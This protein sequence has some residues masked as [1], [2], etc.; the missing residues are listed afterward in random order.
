[1]SEIEQLK[2]SIHCPRCSNLHAH[3]NRCIAPALSVAP[4][5]KFTLISPDASNGLLGRNSTATDISRIDFRQ[6]DPLCGPIYV[7]GAEPGDALML[8]VV[9]LELG[10]W[11]WSG[12][13]PDFGLLSDEFPEPFFRGFDLA[14]GFAE[15]FGER[16]ALRPMLGVLGVAPMQDGDFASIAPTVAGGNID[17]RYITQGA[18]LYLPVFNDGALISGGDGHA[19]Q[20][21]GEISGT[22]I[23]AAMSATIKVE[24]IKGRHLRAPFADFSTKPYVETEYRDFL[25]IGP[26]LF[27]A[28]R[29]AV[30]F[31][32]DEMSRSLKVEPF[33]AYAVLGMIGE[34]RIHEIVDKPNWVVGCMI[35]RRLFGRTA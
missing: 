8:E 32:V 21:E 4:G 20:G 22:A 26:D 7:D 35:P 34:L 17:V 28:A 1:M 9:E 24:L 10:G 30:R 11:G 33:E 5:D 29:D 6:L 25:G 3:W 18:K 15:I 31:A 14:H 16:F 2:R 19:L 23:E 27:T 12:L 13:L